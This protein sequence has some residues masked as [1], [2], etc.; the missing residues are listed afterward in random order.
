MSPD[1]VKQILLDTKTIAVVG[2]SSRA[3]QPAHDVP[4]YLQA[5]GYRIIPVNP[6][7]TEILGETAY[8]TL[9]AIPRTISIELV[10]MFLKPE[11]IAAATEEAIARGVKVIWMQE[12]VRDELA[13]Q[14]ARAAGIQVVMDRCLR[15]AHRFFFAEPKKE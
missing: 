2:L 4:K 6:R 13:A 5:H 10:Q 14:R 8:P 7:A 9:T 12:G 15:A 3:G 1:Q 11:A